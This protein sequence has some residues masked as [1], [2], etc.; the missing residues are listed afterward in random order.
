MRTKLK[1][2]D[3]Y[4]LDDAAMQRFIV[5]GF[6]TL[7]SD[8]PDDYHARMY[9]ELEPLDERGHWATTTSYHARLI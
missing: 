1:E 8:L 5:E 2:K 6:L 7:K 4:L 3:S 9:R